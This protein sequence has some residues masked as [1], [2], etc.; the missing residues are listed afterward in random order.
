MNLKQT[1]HIASAVKPDVERHDEGFSAIAKSGFRGGK[2]RVAVKEK[3][4]PTT[5]KK[6]CARV[7]NGTAKTTK[8]AQKKVGQRGHLTN[9]IRIPTGIDT[10]GD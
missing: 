7:I 4:K 2:L 9:K 1:N 8:P 5:P 3:R 6:T 10:S